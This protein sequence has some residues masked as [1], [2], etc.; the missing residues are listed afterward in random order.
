MSP[1]FIIKIMLVKLYQDNPDP[2]KLKDI[3]KCL[4]KGGIIIY[5]TGG[6]YSIG[7][8]LSQGKSMD[9]VARI[10]GIKPDKANFSIICS[11]L[12]NISEYTRPISTAIFK[13]MKKNLPGHFTFVLEGNNNLPRLF[14]KTKRKT[15]GIR[16]PTDPIP[17]A[18][19][20]LCGGP[21]ISSSIHNDDEILEYITDPELIYEKYQNKVNMVIDGGFGNLEAST[22]VDCTTDEPEIMRQGMGELVL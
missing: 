2:K 4:E 10:Q 18:I 19:V 22:I 11:D 20:E 8:L 3:V 12:S 7:C 17:R 13:L 14:N 6:V 5:P 16:V 21:I 9:T 1:F 15:I